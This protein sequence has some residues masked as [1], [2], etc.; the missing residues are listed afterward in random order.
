MPLYVLNISVIKDQC[1]LQR[2][3]ALEVTVTD[4]LKM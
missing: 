1:N 3:C 4:I 2:V